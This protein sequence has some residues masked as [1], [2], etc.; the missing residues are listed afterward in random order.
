MMGPT[1]QELCAVLGGLLFHKDVLVTSSI[2]LGLHL[3]RLRR[4]LGIYTL[5]SLSFFNR[6]KVCL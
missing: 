6:S 3:Q 5:S 4:F 1:A 2:L